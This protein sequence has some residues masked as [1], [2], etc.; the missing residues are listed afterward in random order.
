M[1][2]FFTFTLAFKGIAASF[3][4]NRSVLSADWALREGSTRIEIL[5]EEA[6][7]DTA[8]GLIA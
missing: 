1:H 5:S 4:V 7:V 6:T 8:V 2:P 3:M